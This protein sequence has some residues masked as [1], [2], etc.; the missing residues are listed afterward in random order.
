MVSINLGLIFKWHL[1]K[2]TDFQIMLKC[3]GTNLNCSRIL[4][5]RMIEQSQC[6]IPGRKQH[7]ERTLPSPSAVGSTH[8]NAPGPGPLL[9]LCILFNSTFND[10]F[11]VTK[12]SSFCSFTYGIKT[13]TLST[14]KEDHTQV[15]DK[16]KNIIMLILWKIRCGTVL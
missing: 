9:L 2:C 6:K 12:R 10:K 16:L 14:S 4:V 11:Q 1:V 13:C 8:T 5:I 15:E 3:S 7:D